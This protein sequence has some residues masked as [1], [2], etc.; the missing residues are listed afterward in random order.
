MLPNGWLAVWR[1]SAEVAHSVSEDD[2][3]T[4]R[5]IRKKIDKPS[6]RG[7]F[8]I[9]RTIIYSRRIPTRNEIDA[10]PLRATVENR[11]DTVIAAFADD[12]AIF[13]KGKFAGWRALI[14]S[15][16]Q[17]DQV[18]VGSVGDL[19]GRTVADLLKILSVLNEHSVGLCL[20]REG[21]DTD[22]GASAILDLIASY[23][24]AKL[25]EAIR[26]GIA[27]AKDHGKV[28]GRPA[29]RNR[30][31][32]RIMDALASGDGVRPTARRFNVSP[33][34]IINIRRS[35]VAVPD[36]LAA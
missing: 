7:S 5:Y 9:M 35:M 23:R 15:L 26:K 32:Q 21:I 12:P 34:T 29:V 22:D 30:V 36:R 31:R 20:H 24:A 8:L 11:G 33:A 28:I 4:N 19:P 6:I 16:D 1:A 25:S 17:A 3:A 13:G 14:A 10:E 2:L 18:V 27:S